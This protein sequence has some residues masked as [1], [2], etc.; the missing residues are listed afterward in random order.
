M[1]L[2]KQAK[3]VDSIHDTLHDFVGQRLKV[4]ANMGRSKIVESEGVLM[5]VHPQLF[6]LE[7]DRKRGRTSRQSY[8]Y[9]DVLTGTVEL[10]D[11]NTGERPSR[12]TVRPP[13]ILWTSR[14]RRRS[15]PNG[16]GLVPANR[17]VSQARHPFCVSGLV[18][19]VVQ[20]GQ[21][22]E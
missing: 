2:A 21:R 12:P 15:C 1:D 10:Y 13:R 7:V 17:R 8:Q 4:R 9:V 3:I 18:S 6:I 14:K 5:Q 11:M 20:R 16:S 19:S 22:I